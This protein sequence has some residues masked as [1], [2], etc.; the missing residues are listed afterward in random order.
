MALIFCEIKSL[1]EAERIEGIDHATISMSCSGR[2]S[3]Q[4]GFIWIYKC[5]KDTIQERVQR[6]KRVYKPRKVAMYDMN[7]NYI[8]TYGSVLQASKTSGDSYM[9]INR[10]LKTGIITKNA[11]HIWKQV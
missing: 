10:Q 4:C 11:I 2:V 6:V 7:G 9:V 3:Y 8:R 5:D 1:A